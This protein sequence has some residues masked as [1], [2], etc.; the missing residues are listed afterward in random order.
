MSLFAEQHEAIAKNYVHVLDVLEKL[1]AKSEHGWYEV[2]H[3]LKKSSIESLTTYS[4]TGDIVPEV[5]IHNQVTIESAY[6]DK[7][8]LGQ[9]KDALL[10]FIFN[11]YD[12]LDGDDLENKII[13]EHELTQTFKKYAWLKTEIQ[14]L[15]EFNALNLIELLESKK[16]LQDSK[17]ITSIAKAVD[18][19]NIKYEELVYLIQD[20]G[21]RFNR[22]IKLISKFL[23][24]SK[25]NKYVD[26][27]V[28][29]GEDEFLKLNKVN[30][31]KAISYVLNYLDDEQ[32]NTTESSVHVDSYQLSHILIDSDDLYYFEPLQDMNVNVRIGHTIHENVRY[33]NISKRKLDIA[34][35][36]HQQESKRIFDHMLATFDLNDSSHW[37]SEKDDTP[38]QSIHPAIDQKH[39]K[40]APELL[41]A[42]QAWEAKYL[43]NEY[44]HQEHTP[45]IT[46]ILKNLAVTQTNLVKRICAITNPKK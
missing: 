4:I 46:N 6:E 37:E 25:F 5:T 28:R 26:V 42:I 44:P 34:L 35:D 19:K 33:G 14:G 3:F 24:N 20:F 8:R 16:P 11:N 23:K 17:K 31:E 38:Q 43:N 22:P 18:G 1:Y 45:A 21:E 41:L 15:A 30:S 2:G 29:L 9:L 36:Y 27:F 40:H 12:S 39:P 10:A 32:F 7:L 13:A